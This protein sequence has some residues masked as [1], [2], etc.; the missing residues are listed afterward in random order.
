MTNG[1]AFATNC[2]AERSHPPAVIGFEWHFSN[3]YLWIGLP[4]RFLTPSQQWLL[5]PKVGCARKAHC[6]AAESCRSRC[7]KA[8]VF[9]GPVNLSRYSICWRLAAYSLYECGIT[10]MSAS[11]SRKMFASTSVGD[12]RNFAY[13]D[14]GL[15]SSTVSITTLVASPFGFIPTIWT[16][17]G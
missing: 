2:S 17:R 14:V 12:A 10:Y 3:C 1:Q 15:P 16:R 5:I 9:Q 13:G 6:P 8:H 7:S 4:G 11:S